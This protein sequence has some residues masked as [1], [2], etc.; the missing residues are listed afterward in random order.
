MSKAP[1]QVGTPDRSAA[2][3]A[4]VA[5]FFGTVQA[6]DFTISPGSVQYSGPEEWSYRRFILH[7]AALCAASDGVEAFCIGSEMRALTQIRG[8]A[9]SF[10]AVAQMINLLHD[11][12]TILGSGVKLTYAADWSEY[13]GYNAGEGNRYFHLDALWSDPELDVIGIDNYMPAADWRDGES[14]LDA[15]AGW[16]SPYDPAY[17]H[18]NI[19]GGEGFDWYY[20]DAKARDGQHR[21]DITD[22]EGEPWIWRYKDLR[23]WWEN[24]HTERLNGVR[25]EDPTDWEPRSKPIWFTEYGCAAIDKGANQPNVFLDAKSSESAAPYFSTG[26]RD[27]LM[28]MQYLLSQHAYWTDP[29]NNPASDVYAGAMVDWSRSHAWAWDARPWPWFPGN[30]DLW[31]DGEN[32]LRGHWLTGR[33]T[34]QPLAAVIAELC[35]RAG[36]TAY[37]VSG[38][39]GVVRGY[40]VASTATGRSALQ[41]LMMAHGVEAVERDGKLIFR[42]RDGR[43]PVALEQGN[44]AARDGGDLSVTRGPEA[45]KTGRLRLT[46]IEAEGQFETRSAEA[47]MPDEVSGDVANSELAVTLTRGEARTAVKRW[48]SEARVA[49]DVARFSLPP[50]STL[51]AGDVVSLKHDGARRLYRIDRMELTGTRDVEAVRIEPGLYRHTEGSDDLPQAGA[52][53]AAV[54][55]LPL[56]LDLPLMRGDEVPH[57]PHLAVTGRP[58]PG[59]VAVYDAPMDGG[60]FSLNTTKGLRATIGVTR[61]PLFTATHALWQRGPGVEVIFPQST[62]LA[63]AEVG[64]LLGGA[65][66]A[67]IG[68]GADWELF[69]FTQ[70][71]L[72]E[73]GV[74]RLS[75]LLRGQF[76][77][78]PLIPSAWAP[79]SLVVL[80]DSAVTQ[81]DLAQSMRGVARRWRIG[82]AALAYDDPSYVESVEAF[83]GIGLR[84]YAPAHLRASRVTP[85]ADL[86]V[87]WTRRTRLGGDSWEGYDVP[88]SEESEAYLVR[89]LYNGTVVR[90][91]PVSVPHYVYSNA[92][93]A[94]DGVAGAFTLSVAQL[95]GTFGP[96]LFASLS[97]PG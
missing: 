37:D 73:P 83:Q 22:G 51:G 3:D 56:F 80:L 75:G 87:A 57:A 88:I 17:L 48:L 68:T 58:W 50:S 67:A 86:S 55:V 96:G 78:D 62:A 12:R 45:E 29:A 23:A 59:S 93:Q 74:W 20:P 63:S 31:S 95:S 49:R 30:V 91:V 64:E 65:N 81:V 35:Q 94:A 52:F 14:H 90:E 11:V 13:F 70:A 25:A 40:A 32:W 5:A 18:A 21:E 9:D 16:K 60:A 36:V 97:V 28:Q 7:Y 27:D 61:T 42:M 84:P 92:D 1:G 77:T 53:Q 4:E 69:Q 43:D 33:A 15:Q 6:T 19:A 46:Y 76:G 54:P 34:N 41:P 38:L 71:T 10:P 72:L 66:L 39:Y 8:D 24:R 82:S 44:L 85:G 2:A 89:V 79:E 26:Q 47:V